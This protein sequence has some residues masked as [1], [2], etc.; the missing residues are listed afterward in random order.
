MNWEQLGQMVRG[1]Y[2]ARGKTRLPSK[3]GT[4]MNA[5]LLEAQARCP[6]CRWVAEQRVPRPPMRTGRRPITGGDPTSA[7]RHIC[8]WMLARGRC[9]SRVDTGR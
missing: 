4:S 2:S 5:T 3:G 6:R 8:E 9:A 1:A 7:V